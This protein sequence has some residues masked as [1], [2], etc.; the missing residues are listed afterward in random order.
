MIDL[1]KDSRNISET[2]KKD[3]LKASTRVIRTRKEVIK[4]LKKE[5]QSSG[6]GPFSWDFTSSWRKPKNDDSERSGSY[7]R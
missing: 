7:Q 6:P 2:D 5:G 1:V 3:V 4:E